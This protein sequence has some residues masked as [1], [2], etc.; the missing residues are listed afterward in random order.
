MLIEF[1]IGL[2]VAIVSGI[3]F[4]LIIGLYTKKK[5]WKMAPGATI[6]FFIGVALLICVWL[7][8]TRAYVVTGQNEYTHYLV[9]GSP[10][11]TM[12]NG[13]VFQ[14]DMSYDECFVI[15]ES[16]NAVVIEEVIYGG[17]AYAGGT[18]WIYGEQFETVPDHLIFYL[19][20]NEPPDEITVSGDEAQTVRLW[21]RHPYE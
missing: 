18:E 9:F 3:V 1:W 5:L 13:T 15:N 2:S 21:L 7:I 11:Y 12:N 19:F 6:G 14:L 10:E 16:E 8:P 20:D 4:M 17:F